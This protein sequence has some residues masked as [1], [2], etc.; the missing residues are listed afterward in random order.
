MEGFEPRS[1]RPQSYSL[2]TAPWL[3][4]VCYEIET[5]RSKWPRMYFIFSSLIFIIGFVWVCA[6]PRNTFCP[7]IH[8]S[9][10]SLQCGEEGGANS[11]CHGSNN[12][13][14]QTYC[15]K[16]QQFPFQEKCKLGVG[17]S[18]TPSPQTA[19]LTLTPV[20][21]IIKSEGEIHIYLCL[22]IKKKQC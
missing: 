6:S 21:A 1:S 8:P 9:F 19:F 22:E 15:W 4:T 3:S 18:W 7:S 20:A 10:S 17:G 13:I 12:H 14:P 16:Q 2:T 5:R 11:Q